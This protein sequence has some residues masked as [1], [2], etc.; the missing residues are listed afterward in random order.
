MY[1]EG[2]PLTT[3]M[4]M[5]LSGQEQR[6]VSGVR[7]VAV[8]LRNRR[9]FKMLMPIMTTTLPSS[10]VAVLA[11]PPIQDSG[12]DGNGVLATDLRFLGSVVSGEHCP[13]AYSW[14]GCSRSAIHPR[15]G[16]ETNPHAPLPTVSEDKGLT[17]NRKIV[18]YLHGQ[19]SERSRYHP[20]P[21]IQG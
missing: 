18:D 8:Y 15:G 6:S 17:F 19:R 20:W 11:K 7:P 1:A 5:G 13:L 12:N 14:V 9:A 10:P 16:Q 4:T 21:D 3:R 2:F